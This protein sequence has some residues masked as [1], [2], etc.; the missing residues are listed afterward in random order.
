MIIVANPSGEATA[1]VR[2]EVSKS[3]NMT[4]AGIE[5]SEIRSYVDENG[6]TVHYVEMEVPVSLKSAYE[7]DENT[8]KK[9]EARAKRCLI[10][11]KHKA[12]IRCPECNKCSECPYYEK[13]KAGIISLDQYVEDGCPE[14]PAHGTPEDE[15]IYFDMLDSLINVASEKRV[16]LGQEVKLLHA[17]VDK[18]ELPERMHISE[19]TMYEDLKIIKDLLQDIIGM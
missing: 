6:N 17:G 9:R 1:V 3:E 16:R 11:G 7:G 13:K 15:A 19:T 2:V 8:Q 5:R 10:P 4:V 12:L 18:A 14:I